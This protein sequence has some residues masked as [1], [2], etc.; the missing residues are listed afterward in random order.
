MLMRFSRRVGED[1]RASKRERG[2]RFIW[3]GT[4]NTRNISESQEGCEFRRQKQISIYTYVCQIQ[5]IR[6]RAIPVYDLV[7]MAFRKL[8]RI[9][10]V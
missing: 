2:R 9:T 4:R 7:S 3:P 6:L 5:Q 10:L 8:A 1:E